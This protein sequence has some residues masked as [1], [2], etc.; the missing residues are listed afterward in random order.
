MS[1]VAVTR[2]VSDAINN[3]EL[4][5]VAR[6][7]ID[8]DLARAQH[9]AYEAML[10]TA[11]RCEIVRLEPA[12]DLP[13]AVFFEDTAV[14]VDEVGIITR[15]GAP[16]RRPETTGV[17]AVL[18]RYRELRY[19]D[20]PGTVDGG[21][22]V[23]VGR[24]VFVGRSVRTNDA[25]IAQLRAILSPFGYN[26]TGVKVR[27]CLHL[28]SAATMLSENQLLVNP[29]WIDRQAFDGLEL[30]EVDQAEPNAANI[31]STGDHFLYSAAVPLTRDR[32]ER[33]GI[34]LNI[35]DVSELAKAEGAVTCCSILVIV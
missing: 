1:R 23:V 24:R 2:A 22:V 12:P 28:K 11:A 27:G 34:K 31:L 16:S 21:D 3:C 5:H 35:T 4:T 17:A 30:V 26:V 33:R 18:G 29:A 13:D 8:L 20:P 6:K 7:P 14:V 10:E 32:L 19:V 25:G 9:R 15:P